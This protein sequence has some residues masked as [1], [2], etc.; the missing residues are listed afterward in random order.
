MIGLL[1][2]HCHNG[3]PDGWPSAAAGFHS[4]IPAGN[5]ALMIASQ[6]KEAV[7]NIAKAFPFAKRI[8]PWPVRRALSARL[9]LWAMPDL[10]DR[11]YL[12]DVIIPLVCARQPRRVLLVGCRRYTA[13]YPRLFCRRGVE[14]WTMDI[15]PEAARWG[16]PRRHITGDASALDI[17]PD[18]P[19][20]DSVVFNGILGFGINDVARVRRTFRGFA[21]VLAPGSLIVI[22]WDTDYTEDPR[23][24][25][26]L[27]ALFDELR[28]PLIHPRQAFEGSTHVYDFFVRNAVPVDPEPASSD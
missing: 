2:E 11:R 14:A 12:V 4:A 18:F 16:A 3:N 10:P 24:A 19:E 15:D 26:E 28:D 27:R 22:G 1:A 20:F 23:S 6:V 9:Y 25:S 17:I 8:V 7:T 21:R 5:H 13:S